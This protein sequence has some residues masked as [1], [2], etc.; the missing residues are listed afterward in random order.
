MT[1][2]TSPRRQRQR[3]RLAAVVAI[4]L[5]TH[6]VALGDAGLPSSITATAATTKPAETIR[7]E[8]A[9]AHIAISPHGGTILEY[10]LTGLPNVLDSSPELLDVAG[11]ELVPSADAPAFA[12]NGHTTWVAPQ[13]E[14][15]RHQDVSERRDN[16]P[17]D[18]WLTAAAYT[19]VDQSPTHLT[20][21]SPES[22][23][24]GVQMVKSV[25][26]HPDGSATVEATITNVRD[27]P[28]EWAVWSNTRVAPDAVVVV[29][30]E[31]KTSLRF[32]FETNASADTIPW[33]YELTAGHWIAD[34]RQPQESSASDSPI[35]PRSG[36]AFINAAV[37]AAAAIHP[38][39]IFL[40]RVDPPTKPGT[41]APRHATVEIYHH[42]GPDSTPLVELELHGPLHQL[43]PA[44]S[45]TLRELWQILPTDGLA[46]SDRVE[47]ASQSLRQLLPEPR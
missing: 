47:R 37:T 15:W 42:S 6:S 14:W 19:V 18:P 28:V 29:P 33:T 45:L 40:K 43:A 26:L 38:K 27:V 21:K 39:S 2:R 36:K 31:P 35:L 16:W 25:T 46:E 34:F 10:A 12:L 8:N 11:D 13:H 4:L 24:W 9:A 7:L 20:L 23:V 17:P 41:T 5:G 44:E 30:V 3:A 32:E 22:P 1:N